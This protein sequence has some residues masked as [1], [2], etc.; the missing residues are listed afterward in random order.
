MCT[1]D[2]YSRTFRTFIVPAQGAGF[3]NIE[4][5]KKSPA[6]NQ[7]RVEGAVFSQ[8]KGVSAASASPF[9]KDKRGLQGLGGFFKGVFNIF[10]FYFFHGF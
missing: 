10:I 2:F 8:K 4:Y 9:G 1:S 6:P 5:G 7:P 3:T